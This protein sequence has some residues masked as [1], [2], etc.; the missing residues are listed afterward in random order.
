MKRFLASIAI[1]L[2]SVWTVSAQ[3]LYFPT[4]TAIQQKGDYNYVYKS[5]TKNDYPM[6]CMATAMTI[7]MDYH[8]SPTKYDYNTVTG[9]NGLA[10]L[11]YDAAQS[12]NTQYGENES[13]AALSEVAVQLV[14]SFEFDRNSVKYYLKASSGMTDEEWVALIVR[15][16]IR[17]YHPIHD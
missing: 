14:N 2:A 1:L 16:K 11:M 17:N 12:I 3:Q 10:Q 5:I 7:I 6:G 8:K 15:P 13:S 9:D 4:N